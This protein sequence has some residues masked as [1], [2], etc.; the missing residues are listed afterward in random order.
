LTGKRQLTILLVIVTAIALGAVFLTGSIDVVLYRT[1]LAV[2]LTGGLLS[3]LYATFKPEIARLADKVHSRPSITV[4]RTDFRQVK[5]P[6]NWDW[7]FLG[8]IFFYAGFILFEG[9]STTYLII[10]GFVTF[11]LAFIVVLGLAISLLI[12]PAFL[13]RRGIRTAREFIARRKGW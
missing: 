2:L 8:V 5:P 11:N 6:S 9:A 4:E 3:L 10:L 13:L 12:I 1:E 7:F